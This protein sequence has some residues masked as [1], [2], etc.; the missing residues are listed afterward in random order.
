M[1]GLGFVKMRGKATFSYCPCCNVAVNEKSH[2]K[3]SVLK[4][5][6]SDGVKEY[7]SSLKEKNDD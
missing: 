5:T 3:D 4:K 7:F 6:V 1:R 2:P